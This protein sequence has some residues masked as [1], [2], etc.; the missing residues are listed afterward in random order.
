MLNF[1]SFQK[2]HSKKNVFVNITTYY[3]SMTDQVVDI[4]IK[5]LQSDRF[6]STLHFTWHGF[7][8]IFFNSRV[9]V[10]HIYTCQSEVLGKWE[11]WK[12]WLA[13]FLHSYF[14]VMNVFFCFYPR[15]FSQ[16]IF[17]V[18]TSLKLFFSLCVLFMRLMLHGFV[19]RM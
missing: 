3:V 13:Y 10:L 6:L 4:F 18:F 14:F 17:L 19:V 2:I 12:H 11:F 15:F 16:L 5:A 7:T 8:I 1:I 9:G